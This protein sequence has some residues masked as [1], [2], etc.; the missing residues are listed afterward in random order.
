MPNVFPF[1][2]WDPAGV[3]PGFDYD[4]TDETIFTQLKVV[5]GEIVVPGGI[6][7]RVLVLPNHRVLSLTVLEKLKIY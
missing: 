2:D 6:S 1:K 3:M 5:N 7:Y 4:V